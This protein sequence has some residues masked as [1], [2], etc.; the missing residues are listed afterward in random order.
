MHK[1]KGPFEM[2]AA[3]TSCAEG[4]EISSESRC[5][6]ASGWASSLGLK[7]KRPLVVGSWPS[8]PLQCSIQVGLDDAVHFNTNAESDNGRFT[9][10]EFVMLCEAGKK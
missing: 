7:P 3:G 9:T 4:T 10:G 2:Y 1:G 5:K 8:V 6:E